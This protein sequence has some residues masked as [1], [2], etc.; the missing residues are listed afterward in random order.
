MNGKWNRL[1]R[2]KPPLFIHF[3]CKLFISAKF[4]YTR[5]NYAIHILIASFFW[6]LLYWF[7]LNFRIWIIFYVRSK[8]FFSNHLKKTFAIL[9]TNY[10]KN[11]ILTHE[12][13][14]SSDKILHWNTFYSQSTLVQFLS[15][16]F[17]FSNFSF[18]YLPFQ[19]DIDSTLIWF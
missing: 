6:F 18:Y 4:K 3:I 17:N 1:S 16:Q 2:D 11:T 14:K 12:K 7:I 9:K 15:I 13:T 10:F 8:K 19:N 5:V